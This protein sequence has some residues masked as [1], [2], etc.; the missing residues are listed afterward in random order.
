[1]PVIFVSASNSSHQGI[2]G[3]FPCLWKAL[4][5]QMQPF[6][7]GLSNAGSRLV[8]LWGKIVLRNVE[9]A[10][11]GDTSSTFQLCLSCWLPTGG[12]IGRDGGERRD[13]EGSTPEQST[14]SKHLVQVLRCLEN[15]SPELLCLTV[16]RVSGD[17][18]TEAGPQPAWWQWRRVRMA[19]TSL[20]SWGVFLPSPTSQISIYTLKSE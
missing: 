18:E 20:S 4:C 8:V 19:Q 1:M 16:L 17:T 5:W 3:F 11:D 2:S 14:L 9:T 10:R 15:K 7:V 13:K 6:K 12:K